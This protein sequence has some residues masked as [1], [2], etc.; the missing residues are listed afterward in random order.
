MPFSRIAG[1][2]STG[3]KPL[4][5]KDLL[6]KAFPPE[7]TEKLDYAL[8]RLLDRVES[9]HFAETGP[10]DRSSSK[11]DRLKY[12]LW[13]GT[14]S[15]KHIKLPGDFAF[16]E[17]ADLAL[18]TRFGFAFA[19]KVQRVEHWPMLEDLDTTANPG[20]FQPQ[21]V[22][23]EEA[24]WAFDKHGCLALTV[25]QGDELL[26]YYVKAEVG[27]DQAPLPPGNDLP[28]GPLPENKSSGFKKFSLKP[29]K[30]S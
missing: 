28:V 29:L 23:R 12:T 15:S 27:D 7:L 30:R 19:E 1:A 4:L 22:G 10:R 11:S 24:G 13:R 20:G 17:A 25:V 8:S 6:V 2:S 21:F 3:V 26:W 9:V 14:A 5:A 16:R 18:L